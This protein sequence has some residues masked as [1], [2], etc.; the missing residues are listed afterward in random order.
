MSNNRVRRSDHVRVQ[1]NNRARVTDLQ[2]QTQLCWDNVHP[3]ATKIT[4]ITRD[5][6]GI[7]HL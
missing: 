4:A 7:F 1:D 2:R 6:N 5:E 3:A